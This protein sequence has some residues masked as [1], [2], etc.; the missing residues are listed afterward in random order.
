LRWIQGA[1]FP[2]HVKSLCKGA[3]SGLSEADYNER[4]VEH[5][6]PPPLIS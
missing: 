2:P 5:F 4:I 6:G 1:D 3:L